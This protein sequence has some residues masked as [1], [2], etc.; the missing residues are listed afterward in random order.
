MARREYRRTCVVCDKPLERKH[1]GYRNQTC[2]DPHCLAVLKLHPA[3][4]DPEKVRVF[5]FHWGDSAIDALRRKVR[6][7]ISERARVR[8]D[9]IDEETRHLFD[10]EGSSWC[11]NDDVLTADLR[12]V[13]NKGSQTI[14]GYTSRVAVALRATTA[15]GKVF[16]RIQ[17]SGDQTSADYV[18]EELFGH[19]G[20]EDIYDV[21][22]AWVCGCGRSEYILKRVSD[23][24]D[25]EGPHGNCPACGATPVLV[26][27]VDG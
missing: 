10:S 18:R 11:W 15:A 20:L 9:E 7:L 24:P 25:E 13:T 17:R 19:S 26:E 8:S 23:L 21:W 16:L 2:K 1:G 4:S 22:L 6:D 27:V 3:L 5:P 12:A 14:W